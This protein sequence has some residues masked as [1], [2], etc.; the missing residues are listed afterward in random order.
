M[1]RN[2]Q[3]SRERIERAAYAIAQK[4]GIDAVT[5]DAVADKARCSSG[6]VSTYYSGVA[7]K[8][9]AYQKAI[10]AE[11]LTLVA[12]LLTSPLRGHLDVPPSV[13]RDAIRHI[14]KK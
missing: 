2:K 3:N 5:R 9:A 8:L 10:D 1:K 13:K 12:H 4:L 11:D 7:L 14:A 6:L